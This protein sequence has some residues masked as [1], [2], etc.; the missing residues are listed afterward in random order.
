M[1]DGPRR[2]ARPQHMARQTMKGRNTSE[3]GNKMKRT[4][5]T[6]ILVPL[7]AVKFLSAQALIIPQ[8]P[9]GQNWR[10]TL[11]VTN[12][13]TAAATAS[14][15]F[16]QNIDATGDTTPWSPPLDANVA[17]LEVPAGSS[18]FVHS[19][20][21]AAT[22]TQGWAQVTSNPPGALQAYVI[23]TYSPPNKQSSDGTAQAISL[24]PASWCLTM[25][26]AT[27]VRVQ[28]C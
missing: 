12:T 13:T 22:L 15:T 21:T 9:D 11:V 20:G 17:D 27:W 7:F 2:I 28:R 6:L 1:I 18:V 3:K 23:Y 25:R 5:R 24:L 4:L 8:A 26:P 14:I 19:A 10:F 16:F